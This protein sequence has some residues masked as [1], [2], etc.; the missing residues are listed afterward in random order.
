MLKPSFTVLYQTKSMR[1]LVEIFIFDIL[2]A[3][4]HLGSDIFIIISYFQQDDPW[5]AGV[6]IAAVSAP[7]TLGK[8][9]FSREFLK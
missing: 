8:F 3:A 7:G 5:W 2:L 4:I 6:T 1:V 9:G